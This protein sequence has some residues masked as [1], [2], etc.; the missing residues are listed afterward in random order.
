MSL[1]LRK[2]ENTRKNTV[3]SQA[4]NGNNKLECYITKRFVREKHSSLLVISKVMKEMET[5]KLNIK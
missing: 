1:G 4:T 3:S 5:L 2:L